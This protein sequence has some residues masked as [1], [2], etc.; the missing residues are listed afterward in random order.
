MLSLTDRIRDLLSLSTLS[1]ADPW[2]IVVGLVLL[3]F[4]LE[5]AAMAAGA[6]LALAG[7][8]S[9][10]LAFLAVA[11]GITVGDVGLYGGGLLGRR[12]PRLRRFLRH[13]RAEAAA[14]LLKRHLLQAVLL[15]RAIP[16]MRLPTYTAAGLFNVP[17]LPFII[18]VTLCVGL[19]TLAF[20]GLGAGLGSALAAL[21]GVSPTVAML[22]LAVPL[23]LLPPLIRLLFRGRRDASAGKRPT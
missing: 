10:P 20:F 11:G 3:S 15:A 14:S 4:L 8:I 18:C 23:I 6:T 22:L 2:M 1:A 7:S 19:W 9:W 21:L 12:I 13:D 16:G 5:D 17:A